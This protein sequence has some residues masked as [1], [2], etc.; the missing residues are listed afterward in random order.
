MISSLLMTG[1]VAPC[2]VLP[3][4][5]GLLSFPLAS[6][7][8]QQS[9]LNPPPVQSNDCPLHAPYH[10]I[11]PIFLRHCVLQWIP[12]H[13]VQIQCW[14]SYCTIAGSASCKAVTL[15]NKSLKGCVIVMNIYTKYRKAQTHMLCL[16]PS[17]SGLLGE[18][19]NQL[20]A[21]FPS[22]FR[23]QRSDKE[24]QVAQEQTAL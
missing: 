19:T 13:G 14:H 23:G 16:V 4:A 6:S 9:S 21:R 15:F 20:S 5:R 2:D 18:P 10:S 22:Y 3:D 17:F 24:G 11:L 8:T 12:K 1:T 7:N